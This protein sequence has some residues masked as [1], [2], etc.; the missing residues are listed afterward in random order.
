MMIGAAA[1]VAGVAAASA[2][3]AGQHV[4]VAP[5]EVKW[6]AAPPSLSPGA[7]AAVLYGDPGKEGAFA[8]RIKAPKG[9][10]IAP[11][12][13]PKPEIVTVLS[14][15]LRLGMGETADEAKAKP[16]PAGSFFALQPGMAHFVFVDEDVVIQVNSSGPWSI[17]YVNPSDDPRKK[18]Q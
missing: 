15:A 11:H 13:H 7:Q 8:L 10:R 1:L 17:D 4:V 2:Q 6:G 16:L 18:T 3:S 14:G 5:G 9:Y 12:T